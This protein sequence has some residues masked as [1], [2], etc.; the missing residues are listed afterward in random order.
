MEYTY[1]QL[2]NILNGQISHIKTQVL[3]HKYVLMCMDICTPT[4]AACNEPA[5]FK[6]DSLKF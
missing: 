5:Y 2:P 1:F 3:V 4:E 6:L